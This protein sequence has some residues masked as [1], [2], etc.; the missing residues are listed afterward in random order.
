[1]MSTF[2]WSKCMSVVA[3]C[4]DWTEGV[5]VHLGMLTVSTCVYLI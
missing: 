4:R 2:N 5:F 1:M 3:K